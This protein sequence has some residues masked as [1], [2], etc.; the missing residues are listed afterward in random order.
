MYT[1]SKSITD[2]F[3]ESQQ[4]II[5]ILKNIK[6]KKNSNPYSRQDLQNEIVRQVYEN[7]VNDEFLQLFFERL[8]PKPYC[9]DTLQTGLQ[10]RPKATAATKVYVQPN[11]IHCVYWV[12]L[13][14]DYAVEKYWYDEFPTPNLSIENIANGHQHI[15][16]LLEN[17]VYKLRQARQKPLAL[18]ADVERGLSIEF[19]ADTNYGGLISK[20]PLHPQWLVHVWHTN[21]YT[22]GD[23]LVNVPQELR[24][25]KNTKPKEEIGVGRNCALFDHTRK[26]AYNQ[27]HKVR[28]DY[29]NLYDKVLVCATEFNAD[30]SP[31]L[32]DREVRC[33][34]R[35]IC[36][37][38]VRHMDGTGFSQVQSVR[39]KAGNRKSQIIHTARSQARAEEAKALYAEGKTQQQIGLML[40]ISER[41]VR[42]LLKS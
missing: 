8:S 6:T 21:P 41:W 20:N 25:R 15:M 18:L 34:T 22:L 14:L 32:Q 27:A 11:P 29:Q 33:T 37:W 4:Q 7:V 1:N 42:Q 2:K 23:L 13:D 28:Y 36:R 19:R 16:Y 38:T 35:S 12:V 26:Y 39:G 30:F 9:T 31:P 5:D 17:P 24:R 40:G 10:I 3:S